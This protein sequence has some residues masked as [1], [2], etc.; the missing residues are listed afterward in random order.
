MTRKRFIKL[1]MAQGFS[2]NDAVAI[3]RCVHLIAADRTLA[4]RIADLRRAVQVPE[5][6]GDG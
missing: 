3:V 1:L 5:E 6:G 4:A 2:R